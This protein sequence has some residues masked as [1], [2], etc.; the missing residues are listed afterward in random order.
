MR[1]NKE[2]VDRNDDG[3]I[4]R[5]ERAFDRADK[6]DDGRV[7]PRERELARPQTSKPDARPN[8]PERKVPQPTPRR[9]PQPRPA[10][11]R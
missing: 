6:N 5:K 11:K 3:K 10:P 8:T 1:E 4:D 7:G 9:E 2:R